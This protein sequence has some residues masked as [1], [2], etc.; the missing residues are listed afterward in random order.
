ML[1]KAIARMSREQF[2]RFIRYIYNEGNADTYDNL[3]DDSDEGM[4]A[5]ACKAV[6]VS[7]LDVFEEDGP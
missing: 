4:M 2:I 1:K 5:L 7:G 6:G 3:N